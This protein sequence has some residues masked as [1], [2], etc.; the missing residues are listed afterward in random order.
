C[1]GLRRWRARRR[2]LRGLPRSRVFRR[3]HVPPLTRCVEGRA[4]APR[5]PPARR[6]LPAARYAVRD[7][8]PQDLRR[9]RGDATALPQLVGGGS[10][11]RRRFRSAADGRAGLRRRRDASRGGVNEAISGRVAGISTGPAAAGP[12]VAEPAA[13]EPAA[14]YA[15]AAAAAAPVV[16]AVPA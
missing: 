7:R 16:D 5:R 15:A 1:R 2:P 14:R 11:R 8:S 13:A 10:G 3:K 4:G 9:D 6:G 12:A